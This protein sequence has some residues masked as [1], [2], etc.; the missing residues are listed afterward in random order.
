MKDYIERQ[1]YCYAKKLII[2]VDKK[3]IKGYCKAKDV[4]KNHNLLRV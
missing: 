3:Q 2:D 4:T 1:L